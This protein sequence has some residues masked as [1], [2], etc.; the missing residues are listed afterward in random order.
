MFLTPAMVDWIGRIA[1]SLVVLITVLEVV[2]SKPTRHTVLSALTAPL[3]H[4][5]WKPV[6]DFV[7][8]VHW[9]TRHPK[10]RE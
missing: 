2:L 3:E 10:G 7:E 9:E 8:Y 5:K 1:L 4:V 6:E